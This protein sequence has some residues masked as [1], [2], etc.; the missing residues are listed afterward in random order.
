MNR[1]RIVGLF[2]FTAF[3]AANANLAFAEDKEDRFVVH[4]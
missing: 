3:L 2:F 4:E 1:F